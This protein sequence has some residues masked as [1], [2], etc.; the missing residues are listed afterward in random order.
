MKY[1]LGLWTLIIAIFSVAI[2][3]SAQAEVTKGSLDI[4]S[5]TPSVENGRVTPDT[6]IESTLKYAIDRS[7]LKR[8]QFS[9]TVLFGSSQG[10]NHLFNKRETRLGKANLFLEDPSG[11][12]KF[13][14]PM[15]AVWADPRLKRPVS[16]IFFI[17]Q[18]EK[19]GTSQAIASA[20]P[21]IFRSVP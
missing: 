2:G 1:Y 19:N 8:N 4:L 12:V 5:I 13:K 17:I 15:D 3:V 11:T 14:Y 18:H 9:V 6:V 16:I 20:G 10:E 7:R 21:F